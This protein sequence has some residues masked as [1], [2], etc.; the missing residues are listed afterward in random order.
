[1]KTKL[2]LSFVGLPFV[3]LFACGGEGGDGPPIAPEQE[4]IIPS[5]FGTCRTL[6]CSNSDCPGGASCVAIN[7]AWGTLGTCETTSAGSGTV[8]PGAWNGGAVELPAGCWTKNEAECDPRTN[9]GCSDDT[10]CD[11]DPGD[12]QLEP[13]V[14]CF[15][16]V[17][18]VASGETCDALYG[19]Y[20]VAGQHCRPDAE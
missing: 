20:C 13:M 15:V 4:E 9:A 7:P 2:R 19:P 18:E 12:E 17:S 16:G 14:G 3:I 1:M 5:V 8:A 6:C 10:V 11:L